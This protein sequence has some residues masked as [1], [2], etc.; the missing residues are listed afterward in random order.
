[1]YQIDLI[2]AK[3]DKLENEENTLYSSYYTK[4]KEAKKMEEDMEKLNETYF[5]NSYLSTKN[6]PLNNF[7][8]DPLVE[9]QISNIIELNKQRKPIPKTILLC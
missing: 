8:S 5:L 4:V 1:L 2:E 3:I 7:V 6:A 9:K